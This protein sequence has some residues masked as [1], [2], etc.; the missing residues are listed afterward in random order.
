[1]EIR[2]SAIFFATAIVEESFLQVRALLSDA[3]RCLD[4]E[5]QSVTEK[6]FTPTSEISAEYL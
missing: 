4:K 5:P 3:D 1:M 2:K 6:T